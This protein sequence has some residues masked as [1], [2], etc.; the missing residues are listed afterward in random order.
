MIKFSSDRLTVCTQNGHHFLRHSWTH[1]YHS[2][3]SMVS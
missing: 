2:A 3:W 1:H